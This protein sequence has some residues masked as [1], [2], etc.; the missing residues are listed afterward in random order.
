VHSIEVPDISTA[1]QAPDQKKPSPNGTKKKDVVDL[2][3]GIISAFT[4]DA[5]VEAIKKNPIGRPVK[6]K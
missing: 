2:N 4:A 5:A 1:T 6:T 3:T